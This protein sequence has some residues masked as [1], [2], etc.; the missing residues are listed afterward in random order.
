MSAISQF[1]PSGA[2]GG[3][4]SSSE[5]PVEIVGMSGGGGSGGTHSCQS[6]PANY[7]SYGGTG[8]HGG[9]FHA[10]NYTITPGTTVPITIGTGGA[11][12]P[13]TCNGSSGCGQRGSNGTATCFNYP[14]Q[15][16]VVAG[17]GGGG[18]GVFPYGSTSDFYS[19]N[20]GGSGGGGGGSPNPG[21]GG[22]GF[23]H[24]RE[25]SV[26]QL[27]F[28]TPL[29]QPGPTQNANCQILNTVIPGEYLPTPWGY[30]A[31]FPGGNGW[32]CCCNNNCYKCGGCGGG[33]G[34]NM[35]RLCA[36][37]YSPSGNCPNI[38]HFGDR[39]IKNNI[40]GTL[41]SYGS[42]IGTGGAAPA[43]AGVAGVLVIKWP[44][45]H[46]AAPSYPG[47]TD[48]SPQTPGYYTYCFTSSG[49]ITLP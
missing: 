30:M 3:G 2:S 40:T 5:I 32:I 25:F 28:S 13:D 24:L 8:G 4:G 31:G 6:C 18:G 38:T 46:G 23:Y 26:C 1:F 43:G 47:A 16:I 20:P 21:P 36:C 35:I 17:G 22:S 49:S 7:Y 19:G 45:F 34:Q 33:V 11:A 9:F 27:N 12:A 14:K 41:V 15:P 44:S 42:T 37:T 10:T 39:N 48:I 29:T